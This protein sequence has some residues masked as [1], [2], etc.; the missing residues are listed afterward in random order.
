MKKWKEH[1]AERYAPSVLC[2]SLGGIPVGYKPRNRAHLCSISGFGGGRAGGGSNN[3]ET[4]NECLFWGQG[5]VAAARGQSE[6]W[7]QAHCAQ[8]QDSEVA[9][10]GVG[11]LGFWGGRGRGGGGRTP[12]W[13]Q[14]LVSGLLGPPEPRNRARSC[15]ILGLRGGGS[16]SRAVG[17]MWPKNSQNTEIEHVQCLISGF[18]GG[19]SRGRAGRTPKQAQMLVLEL[20][21]P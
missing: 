8:F 18:W 17:V 16:R 6:P 13:A 14:M 11:Q 19:G 20:W 7:N 4:S 2:Q 5:V 21:G 10:A 9:A 1:D 12:K 15:S 3:P